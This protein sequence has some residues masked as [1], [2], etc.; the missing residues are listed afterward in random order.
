M[1]IGSMQQLVKP[2]CVSHATCGARDA[3]NGK[4]L[5]QIRSTWWKVHSATD[6]LNIWLAF[7]LEPAQWVCVWCA[8]NKGPPD[9]SSK[10]LLKAARLLCSYLIEMYVAFDRH[11]LVD[12]PKAVVCLPDVQSRLTIS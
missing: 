4:A 5:P 10:A 8:T 2:L 9:M 3:R 6:V 1:C 12:P 11:L 7:V